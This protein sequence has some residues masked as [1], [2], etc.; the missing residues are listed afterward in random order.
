MAEG[1][2]SSNGLD[3][4]LYYDAQSGHLCMAGVPDDI[5]TGDNTPDD[6]SS[7]TGVENIHQVLLGSADSS[8][9]GSTR[10]FAP[11]GSIHVE[12]DVNSGT[13]YIRVA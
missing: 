1:V 11:I 10:D 3:A 4:A 9:P 6:L 8:T 13:P 7:T 12:T 2:V 5:N